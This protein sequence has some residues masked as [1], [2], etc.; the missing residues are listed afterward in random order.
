MSDDR[1]RLDACGCCEGPPEEPEHHNPPGLDALAYRIGTH[2]DFLGRMRRAIHGWTVPD[3]EHAGD[4]PLAAL[5]TRD[6]DDPAIAMMDAA[7]TVLDVLTFYQERI[8]NEGFLRTATERLSILELARA[9]GYELRPGVAAEAYVAFTV[10]EAEGSPAVAEVPAGTQVQ[11]VPAGG[12]EL[13][14]TF[15]TAEAISAHRAWNTLRPR[16]AAPQP[17]TSG[18]THVWVEG[19]NPGLVPGDRVL[20]VLDGVPHPQQVLRVTADRDAGRTRIDFARTISEPDVEA[21]D[22]YVD[23]TD[24]TLADV[25]ET[26]DEALELTRANV[27]AHVFRKT[28]READL[29]AFLTVHEWDPEAV[30]AYVADLRAEL[31]GGTDELL[32]FRTRAAVFGHNA[33]N[34]R[35]LPATVWASYYGV[36]EYDIPNPLPS[37][38]PSDWPTL[39]VTAPNGTAHPSPALPSDESLT[40]GAAASPPTVGADL[41]A[42]EGMFIERANAEIEATLGGTI[43]GYT[44]EPLGILERMVDLDAVY[45][46]VLPE[47]WALLVGPGLVEPYRITDVTEAARAEYLLSA[48]T[49]RLTLDGSL[50]PFEGSPRQT[51]VHAQE[52]ALAIAALPVTDEITAGQ[53]TLWLRAMVLGL[54]PGQRVA[55]SG[56]E[57]GTDGLV[58]HEILSLD[59]VHHS[60][61]YTRLTFEEK[62][63]YTYERE[64]VEINANVVGASHGETVAGETLGSGDGSVPHQRLG[65][66]KPPLTYVSAPNADGGAASTLTVR[67]DGVAW[68]EVPSLYG[69][70]PAERVYTLRHDEDAESAVQFGDGRAGARL[71]TGRENVRATYRSGIGFEGEVGAGALTL[72]KTRP[73]GIRAVTNPLPAGGAEDAEAL[74]DARTNAP[75]TVLTLDRIVSLR[76]YEDYARAFAGI[77]KAQATAVWTGETETVHLTLA[78]ASG[79]PVTG[80]LHD[81]LRAAVE[82]ARDP[83]RPVVIAPYQPLVFFA[84][85]RLLVDGAYVWDDV[86][87]AAEAALR[88]AFAFERRS[89]AQPATAAEVVEAIHGVP[90]VVALD[91]DAFYATTPEATA[92]PAGSLLN[93]VLDARPARYDRDA[94]QIL[95][96]DLLLVHPLGITLT[97][98]IP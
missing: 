98:L 48:K 96:A 81:N 45:K 20:L 42:A 41:P 62:P 75:V 72:L 93:A 55:L 3:G 85:A 21:P 7:A 51:T 31:F 78:D 80:K 6:A 63:A 38:W 36:S 24:A 19:L 39:D 14:Q 90:G 32:A 56:V 58:R 68:E 8:A 30:L 47:T 86:A 57:V 79:D 35:T 89:F 12:D 74:E 53:E 26:A 94:G 49:T 18:V 40:S 23:A 76:D 33:P 82:G 50:S 1:T 61:G 27:D 25:L 87:A 67:V 71:P 97:P 64:G 73:Y 28:W 92:A 95:P 66:K 9:I 70:G 13:P 54:V 37:S 91:L 77:G 65:L 59:A 52:E 34:W 16:L 43:P 29:Q 15:E 17:L 88:E 84:E 2:P 69:R 5:A 10:D 22:D 44:S 60:G 83:L 4:R 11:S 46:G